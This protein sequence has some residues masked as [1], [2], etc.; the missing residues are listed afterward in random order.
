MT[1]THQHTPV[2]ALEIYLDSANIGE[3]EK[4][5]DLFEL[6]GI[7]SNPLII[8]K[9]GKL[10]F[11]PHFSKIRQIIGKNKR[12]HI[13]TLGFTA[14]VILKEARAILGKIDDH[15][16]IKVPTTEQGLKAMKILSREGV[17][18]TATGI[19]TLMQAYHAI[20]AGANYL[21]P[22]CNRMEQMGINFRTVIS[23]I[24]DVLARTG[25]PAK[26]VAASF[27]N[28]TQVTDAIA[29]GADAVTMTSDVL[30]S[31]FAFAPIDL[32]VKE[33]HDAWISSQGKDASLASTME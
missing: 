24:S 4:G 2:T 23:E 30:H 26:I 7:T 5:S 11:Y 3:I 10:D 25:S 27:K 28:V 31:V 12:L 33:F 19:Y 9:E 18:I 17:N 13:Q 20:A 8:K 6:A 21:A 22:Y 29:A 32:A 14:D 15:V 16:Y 1:N